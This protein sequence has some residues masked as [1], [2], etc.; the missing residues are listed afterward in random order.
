MVDS[1]TDSRFVF[2]LL[3]RQ[4]IQRRKAFGREA[5]FLPSGMEGVGWI[6]QF[7]KQEADGGGISPLHH[8]LAAKKHLADGIGLP[9]RRELGVERPDEI[10]ERLVYADDFLTLDHAKR[11]GSLAAQRCCGGAWGIDPG[12]A[13]AWRRNSLRRLISAS[14]L[15]SCSG[16]SD[17]VGPAGPRPPI[18]MGPTCP[19][20][21][22]PIGPGPGNIP[23]G[24]IPAIPGV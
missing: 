3:R 21:P 22:G 24:V 17:G 6:A 15:R 4:F 16:V 7:Q 19:G 8:L 18:G 14:R 2:D 23:V 12:C 11:F 5:K 1:D 20:A 9:F 13:A 10:G